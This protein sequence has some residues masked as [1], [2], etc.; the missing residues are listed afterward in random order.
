MVKRFKDTYLGKYKEDKE[1]ADFTDLPSWLSFKEE[2]RKLLTVLSD[3]LYRINID[4]NDIQ[5]LSN[6]YMGK[7][8]YLHGDPMQNL[9]KSEELIRDFV[10]KDIR[11]QLL[12]LFLKQHVL[13]FELQ[14]KT[15]EIIWFSIILL[16]MITIVFFKI[17]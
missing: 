10:S 5:S 9:A 14:K 3:F 17:I 16:V 4:E 8:P 7:L 1:Q 12:I 6:E 15:R 13:N 2:Y 11:E